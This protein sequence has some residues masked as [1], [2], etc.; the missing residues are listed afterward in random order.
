MNRNVLEQ[1]LNLLKV[2]LPTPK[3]LSNNKPDDGQV[4]TILV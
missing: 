3:T 1:I 4:Q 2:K